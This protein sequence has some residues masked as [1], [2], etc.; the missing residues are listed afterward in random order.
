MSSEYHSG[1]PFNVP[2]TLVLMGL[3]YWAV[4]E[5]GSYVAFTVVL[6]HFVAFLV[7]DKSCLVGTLGTLTFHSECIFNLL[8]HCLLCFFM[9]LHAT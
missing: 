4:E 7:F 1:C 6:L 9:F 3:V 2:E 8:T 5:Q